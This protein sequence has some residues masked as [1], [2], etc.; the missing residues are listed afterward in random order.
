MS[1]PVFSPLRR[2]QFRAYFQPSRVLLGIVPAETKSGVNVITLCFSMYCSYKPPM[3][4]VAVHN[5]SATY[6]LIQRSDSYVLSVPGI[7]LVDTAM[8]CGTESMK[9]VDKVDHLKIELTEGVTVPVPGL[10]KAIANVEMTKVSTERTGDHILV[11]GRVARFGVNT[12]LEEPPLLS[13]GPNT[14]GY[15]LLRK[16]GIHRLAVPIT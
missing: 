6:G 4:A 2:Q 10:K 9:D 11:V 15:R 3:M 14:V 12:D 16:K 13:I 5:R 8:Y 7:E 1:S